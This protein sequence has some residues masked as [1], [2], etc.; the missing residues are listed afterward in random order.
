MF[1][2]FE[3]LK[4]MRFYLVS[5]FLHL[6][7]MPDYTDCIAKCKCLQVAKIVVIVLLSKDVE[8]V[9]INAR[10]VVKTGYSMQ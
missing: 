3:V 4:N 8:T 9:L 6:R 2:Q 10:I 7:L 1:I 5:T